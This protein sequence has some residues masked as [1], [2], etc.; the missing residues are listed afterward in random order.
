[1]NISNIAV[2]I[3]VAAFLSA[4]CAGP[5]RKLG[6]GLTNISE[7]TRLGELRRSM[8]Q[9]S[10][11]NSPEEG[12]TTG[13]IRGVSETAKRTVVGAYEVMT[14]PLPGYEPILEPEYGQ[15]PDNF[16][17]NLM[18]DSTFATDGALGFSGGDVAPFLLGSR[19]KVFDY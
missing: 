5:E 10:I 7:V 2:C 16:R 17:P 19:F 6:R 8:E 1:M 18:S 4:G 12:M 3:A 11:W 15:F 9:T 13:F 14:F